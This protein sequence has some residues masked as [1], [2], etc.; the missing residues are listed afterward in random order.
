MLVFLLDLSGPALLVL[1]VTLL[2]MRCLIQLFLLL[3]IQL[4]ILGIL[5]RGSRLL[6]SLFLFFGVEILILILTI[7]LHLLQERRI[8]LFT[9]QPILLVRGFL[10]LL[11]AGV[12]ILHSHEVSQSVALVRVCKAL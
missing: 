10:L 6:W 3:I 5:F 1:M 8:R 11:L 9:S 12:P 2:P 7:C 4:L